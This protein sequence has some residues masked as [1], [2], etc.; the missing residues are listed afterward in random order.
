MNRIKCRSCD[1]VN[2]DTDPTCR[3]CG[4]DIGQPRIAR[5]SSKGPRAA[6]KNGSWLYTLLFVTLLGGAAYYLYSGVE[7]SYNEVNET[8][9]TAIQTKQKPPEGSTNRTEADQKRAGSYKNAVQN[10]AGLAES[11]K[12]N[13]DVKKLMEPQKSPS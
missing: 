13:E 9:R 2:A 3:R 1:L 8:T 10:S 7:R 11:Q 12:H 6:A 4:A 5:N